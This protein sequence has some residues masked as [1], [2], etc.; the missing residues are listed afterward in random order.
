[1]VGLRDHAQEGGVPLRRLEV[2]GHAALVAM[3][4]LEIRPLAWAAR[5]LAFLQTL[6]RL[7]LDDVGAP[8][9]ELAHASRPGTHAREV[10]NGEAGKG[11]G[12][13]GKRHCDGSE[14][15]VTA[16]NCNLRPDI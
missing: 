9:G 1:H 13:P 11:L 8:I 12:G 5:A 14:W 15:H 3:Q 16:S 4:V 10:E 7:D 6:R 2:E